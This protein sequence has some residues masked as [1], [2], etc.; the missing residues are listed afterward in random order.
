MKGVNRS[1]YRERKNSWCVTEIGSHMASSE[2]A[3]SQISV[4]SSI[5]VRKQ[6]KCL[7]SSKKK[8]KPKYFIQLCNIS[9]LRTSLQL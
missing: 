4:F 2:Y 3:Y 1:T 6:N 5:P 7:L 8:F 9:M